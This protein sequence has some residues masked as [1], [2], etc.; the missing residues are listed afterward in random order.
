LENVDVRGPG[1]TPPG[2]RAWQLP[3][4][5][6]RTCRGLD[7]FSR[8]KE[9]GVLLRHPAIAA[10]LAAQGVLELDPWLA[11]NIGYVEGR[12]F[13]KIPPSVPSVG[14]LLHASP[15]ARM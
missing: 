13:E 10:R 15:V 11:Q 4:L 8:G 1:G 3:D 7:D 5:P 9:L 2:N 14:T 12:P 6:D